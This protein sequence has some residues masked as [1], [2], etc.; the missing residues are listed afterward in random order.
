MIRVNGK[1]ME[2]REDLT[3]AEIL[4]DLGYTISGHP[5]GER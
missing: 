1:S 3:F 5:P 4:K 2:W